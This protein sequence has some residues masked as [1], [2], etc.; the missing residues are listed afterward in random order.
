MVL[1]EILEKL[2]DVK[3]KNTYLYFI[4]RVLKKDVKS[5]LSKVLDK[6]DFKVYQIDVDDEIREHLHSLTI[7]QLN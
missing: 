2:Q 3:V 6:F 1:Q 5:K 4:T 7:E